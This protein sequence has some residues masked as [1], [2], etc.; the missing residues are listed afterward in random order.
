MGSEVAS[1]P[2]VVEE[3]FTK[4]EEDGDSYDIPMIDPSFRPLNE[5]VGHAELDVHQPNDEAETERSKDVA[6][7]VEDR[8][9]CVNFKLTSNQTHNYIVGEDEDDEDLDDDNEDA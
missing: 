9:S 1:F 8:K 7:K 4:D 3:E 6:T 2:I 5:S